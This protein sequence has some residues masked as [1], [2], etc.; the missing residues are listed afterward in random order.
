MTQ[1]DQQTILKLQ[2]QF[3]GKRISVENNE[4]RYIGTCQ[5]IGPNKF[6]PLFE[7]QVTIDRTPVT[8][9]KIKSI[10]LME[11]K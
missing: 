7:L 4:G 2:E 10:Y 11:D 1:L 9:V 3:L 8:N 5:F 6:F